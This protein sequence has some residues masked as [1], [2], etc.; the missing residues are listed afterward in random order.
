M[1]GIVAIF[2][3]SKDGGVVNPAEVLAIREQMERRGPDGKGTWFSADGRV[4]FGHRRLAVISPDDAGAQ[5]MSLKSAC[6][7]NSDLTVT[8]NGEI[9][10]HAVLRARLEA[11]GHRFQSASDTEVILHLYEDH[12]DDLVDHLR[13]MF[14]F[15]LWDGYAAR[16]LLARD[17]FG[18]KPLYYADDGRQVR[19]ASQARAL[20]RSG[21]IDATPDD[22][23]LAS[24]LM[25]GSIAEP[26][27]AWRAVK[28][29]PAGCTLTVS[30]GVIGTPRRY[31]SLSGVLREA[32]SQSVL[33]PEAV[34]REAL[35]DAVRAHLVADVD[36]GVFLSAGVDSGAI[37]GLAA[38][39]RGK[40]TAITL[41]FEQ[42]QG[43]DA[44]E[45]PIAKRVAALYGAHHVVSI[46]SASDISQAT[47]GV[48][49]AMDQ[50]S[51]DG[52][53]SWLVSR[54]AA[55]AGLKVVLS[56]VGGDELVG[57]YATFASVPLWH[58]RLRVAASVPGLG[59]TIRRVLTMGPP[60]RR[61]KLAG[62][63]EH[64]GS[65]ASIWALH[66]SLFLPWELEALL[67]K[68]RALASLE[69]LDLQKCLDDALQ[70]DPGRDHL[71]VAA[72]EG[73]LYL[74]NQLLRD[75]DW[76]SMD[77]SVEV[78][79]PFVD[80]QLLTAMAPSLAHSWNSQEPKRMT[81]RAPRPSLPM[82]LQRRT[83]SGFAVPIREATEAA[84]GAP[85][86]AAA[87]LRSPRTPWM[88]R[89]AYTVADEFGM[90]S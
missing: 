53:N 72:L 30:N 55:E 42:L 68:E 56:G 35:K 59:I 1:C 25:L 38:E 39:L 19:V 15:A 79:V 62:A 12:G 51:I 86:K 43:S 73:G 4:G 57:G 81:A 23:S 14:A 18:V 47:E 44:D 45:V 5:P 75:A 74:R 84:R 65:L 20:V 76:A 13:G 16:L 36:V 71:R 2:S 37:L 8:F 48:L 89:W 41:G 85:W 32:L 26:S 17:Q 27:T 60:L 10:N 88:R 82:D 69:A 40:M 49:H 29:V 52:L 9:Y 6:R 66:R 64:G 63:V 3:Y 67:G 87:S 83:K 61:P 7:P 50:P 80:A 77:H 33:D 46:L 78:R 28:A 90:L 34:A 24:L 31:F 11:Q 54:A 22:A 70:P 58:H 21:D